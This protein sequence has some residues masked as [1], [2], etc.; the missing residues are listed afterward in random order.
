MVGWEEK[1]K[2]V[3][4]LAETGGVATGMGVW[5]L[6]ELGLAAKVAEARGLAA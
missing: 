2:G 4:G 1:V 3:Q 5:G 6:E